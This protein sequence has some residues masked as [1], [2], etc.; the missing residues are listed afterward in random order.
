MKRSR[1]ASHQ[2]PGGP[3]ASRNLAQFS[4]LFNFRTPG[5]PLEKGLQNFKV[6]GLE[7]L[8]DLQIEEDAAAGGY[9]STRCTRSLP[10][11]NQW[12]ILEWV[13]SQR[14]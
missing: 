12:L 4:T 11:M 8:A 3:K 7:A 2:P 10:G 14:T 9:P 5:L 1:G 13:L 6:K